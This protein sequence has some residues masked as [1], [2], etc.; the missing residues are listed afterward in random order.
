MFIAFPYQPCIT[1]FDISSFKKTLVDLYEEELGRMLLLPWNEEC[2]EMRY[3][4]DIYVELVLEESHMTLNRNEELVELK[5]RK[6]KLAKRIIV[7]GLAGSGKSCLLSKLA[8]EWSKQNPKSPLNKFE[9]VFLLRM[10]DLQTGQTLID[11]ICHQITGII[12]LGLEDYI[13]NNQEQLLVLAD[14]MDESNLQVHS[15][16]LV[17]SQ[18][19]MIEQI[20][21]NTA[22]PKCQVIVSTRPHRHLGPI[23]SKF[24]SDVDV[25]GFS[26]EK[27]KTYIGK[28]FQGR[29]GSDG[30]VEGLLHKISSS[31]ILEAISRI[32]II[33]MLLCVLWED[34]INFPDT[35]T[36]L[37]EEFIRAIWN[38]FCQTSKD[39]NYLYTDLQLELGKVALQGI[40]PQ[41][42]VS[43]DILEFPTEQFGAFSDLGIKV[44]LI[45]KQR[46]KFRLQEKTSVSFLHKSIQ[47]F[48]AGRFLADLFSNNRQQFDHMLNQIATWKLLLQKFELLR[49]CCGIS[50]HMNKQSPAIAVIEF[51]IKKYCMMC[52]D[53]G[54][55]PLT[56]IH[57]GHT[58]EDLDV[59]PLLALF[60]E[61][62]VKPDANLVCSFKDHI[63][64]D[65]E[66]V[67]I[68]CVHPQALTVFHYTVQSEIGR[69]LNRQIKS[70]T[71][72]PLCPFSFS[73]MSDILQHLSCVESLDITGD[74]ENAYEKQNIDSTTRLGEVISSLSR[75]HT[76]CM[77]ADYG[78]CQFDIIIILAHLSQSPYKS[79]KHIDLDGLHVG[80]AIHYM[81]DIITHHLEHLTLDDV[82]LKEKHIETLS[83]FLPNAPNL[84]ELDLQ[85]NTIRTSVVSLVHSLQQCHQLQELYLSNAHLTDAGFTALA[86]S[87]SHWPDLRMIFLRGNDDVGNSGLDAVFR[88]IHHLPQLTD[89][90][91][92][93]H[94][95]RQ[96]S[97]LVRDSL[98][99]IEKKVP[100]KRGKVYISVKN[101]HIQSIQRT[102]RAALHLGME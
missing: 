64:S 43:E 81:S 66:S 31:H 77:L 83:T 39:N 85:C 65:V 7:K 48:C 27:I 82:E 22:L 21:A 95:D 42:N 76:L 3:L 13:H 11:A 35:L 10:R 78:S 26:P 20:L 29:E 99:V 6:D 28:Y 60:Y 17:N 18:S 69:A 86:Q 57:V 5:T 45:T 1:G 9:L 32:P 12:P 73:A 51:A 49:F 96:C 37:Y 74:F 33:L 75:L 36:Q 98:L 34:Q 62:Q 72:E 23:Q 16:K 93:A 101:K 92:S 88:H 38:R 55:Y 4:D 63:Y 8:Y 71:F 24:Y 15:E 70:V 79:L 97:T 50:Q 68:N 41:D 14:G 54:E 90:E 89:L 19:M 53:K 46:W 94:I 100:A 56:E 25:R 61:G 80:D 52:K 40:L 102:V 59:L 87:F 47:E 44:G 2:N 67:K 30:I 58:D 91:I 84:L